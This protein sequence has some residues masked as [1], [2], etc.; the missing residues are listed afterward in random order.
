MC[1]NTPI[2]FLVFNRL[3]S[4]EKVFH[5][6]R[7]AKPKKLYLSVDGPRDK[8]KGET[9]KCLCVRNIIL[10]QIDWD[11]ELFTNFRDKNLG[12]KLAISSGID[13]FFKNEERGIILED[14]TLPDLTFFRF[15]E[16][17]LEYY[18]DDKRL[19]M[20]SGDNFQF[21]RK[22]AQESYYFS[23]YAHIW[24]WATWRRAWNYYDVDMKI[25]PKVRNSGLLFNILGDKKEAFYWKSI[26]DKVY[27]G[28]IDAW[29]YQWLFACWMQNGLNILPGVNLVSNIGFGSIGTHT[30][31]R[32]EVAKLESKE[33]IFPLFHPI[34]MK[35]NALADKFDDKTM[36]SSKPLYKKIVNKIYGLLDGS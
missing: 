34:H 9:E 27:K 6:I 7:R 28:K 3:D 13:W 26:F 2:L 35:R 22:S 32:S 25:W 30:K 29:S 12:C 31:G 21:G 20:I 23:R 18:K 15:C 17:L 24:G 33:I 8:R 14:D 16:E 4:T 1:L 5:Q 36:F 19:M 10:K 11:C